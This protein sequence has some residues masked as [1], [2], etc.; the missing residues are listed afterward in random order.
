MPREDDPHGYM[1][2]ENVQARKDGVR[3]GPFDF[4]VF[5]PDDEEL[6]EKYNIVR[7]D[8]DLLIG[9]I[10]EAG[11]IRAA[12]KDYRMHDLIAFPREHARFHGSS[13]SFAGVDSYVC[14]LL[15]TQALREMK[16]DEPA[17]LKW[18]K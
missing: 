4:L 15:K 8:K 11:H 12:L 2:P 14:V 5:I 9:T 13:E 10:G 17:L 7:G 6:L 16:D 18:E 1:D 3:L